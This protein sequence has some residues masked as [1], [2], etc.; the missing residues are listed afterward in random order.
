MNWSVAPLAG[1]PADASP[2][3][4]VPRKMQEA[5]ERI[6]RIGGSPLIDTVVSLFRDTTRERIDKMRDAAE[7]GESVQVCRLAHAMKGSAAQVGAERLRAAAAALERDGPA[8][9]RDELLR[10]V[11]VIDWELLRAVAS[12]AA[13][14]R[15]GDASAGEEP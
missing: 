14:H 12:L 1:P 7:R 5:L 3:P 15:R 2:A 9:G 4:E 6:R 11:T 10:G 13:F 8:L